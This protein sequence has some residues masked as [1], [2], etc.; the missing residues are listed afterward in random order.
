M[1]LLLWRLALT[2]FAN[3]VA[4]TCLS[5][6]TEQ[7]LDFHREFRRTLAKICAT[8]ELPS[9]KHLKALWSFLLGS[10]ASESEF[11]A[12]YGYVKLRFEEGE[13]LKSILPE[14]LL[15]ALYSP[16]FLVEH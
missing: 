10:D 13:R 2:S 16:Y 9:E 3:D 5:R 7:K 11:D 6:K 1:N 4:A 14:A 15:I 12:W 8:D